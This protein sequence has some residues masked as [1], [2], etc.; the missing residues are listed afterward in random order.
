MNDP[1]RYPHLLS[2]KNCFIRGLRTCL[3]QLLACSCVG[4][5]FAK[6]PGPSPTLMHEASTV[7]AFAGSVVRYVHLPAHEACKAS[8]SEAVDRWTRSHCRTAVAAKR[9]R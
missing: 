2:V 9:S 4:S 1:D 7:A 6:H 8:T 3:G 5:S